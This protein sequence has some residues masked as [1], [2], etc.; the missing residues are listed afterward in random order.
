MKRL[1]TIFKTIYI[2]SFTLILLSCSDNENNIPPELPIIEVQ[3]ST[4]TSF[5]ISLQAIE[6]QSNTATYGICW[7]KNP[8]ASIDDNT[9]EIT[10]EDTS[11]VHVQNL[12][13]N[14][15]YY[16]NVYKEVNGIITYG[17]ERI[18]KTLSLDD[19]SWHISFTFPDFNDLL[20]NSEVD[21]YGDNTTFFE[22]ITPHGDRIYPTYG[23][24]SLNENTLTYL[25]KGSQPNLQECTYIFTGVLNEMQIEGTYEHVYFSQ[26]P[27]KGTML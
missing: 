20:I 6:N 14:T 17:N 15:N 22:E 8:N 11:L 3:N 16:F 21:F 5:F 24:W 19:T 10:L 12:I 1:S 23:S 25:F 27:W 7:S 26:G 2:L 13:A 9:Q 4:Y 18:F